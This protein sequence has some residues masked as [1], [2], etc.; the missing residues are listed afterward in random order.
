M[1]LNLSCIG[2]LLL[3]MAPTLKSGVFPSETSLEKTQ[4]LF[5]S[6]F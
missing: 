5:A 6:G 2:H 4:F 1:P 3:G